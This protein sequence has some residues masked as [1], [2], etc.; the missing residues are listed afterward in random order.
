[1]KEGL[2]NALRSGLILG[3]LAFSQI[4][5][6][7]I[8]G[9]GSIQGTISDPTG[10]V[11][12]GATV[13]ATNTATG[14]KT[15]RTTTA[16]GYYVLSPLPAG[17]YTVTASSTG[18]QSTVQQ[19]IRVDALAT[20]GLN[21]T[22]TVGAATQSVT[23]SS[24][25]PQLDTTNATLG[26]TMRNEV[27]TALPLAMSGGPRDP[28]QF[29][30]LIPG[31]Q[32]GATQAAGTSYASFNGG[33]TYHN[34]VYVE[35]VPLTNAAVQGETRNLSLG[36]SVE[37]IDQFQVETNSA[38]AM[39]QGQGVENYVLKSGGDQFHGAA[40][41]HF[42]NTLLDARGFFPPT[43]PVEKQNEF[44]ANL[45]GPIRKDKLFFF[46]SYDGYRYR[47]GSVPV[48]QSIPTLAE[49]SGD[50]SALPVTIY[51]PTTT[52]CTG[53][54]TGCTRQPFPGNIIPA[55][56]ISK[57][58][59]S[60]QSYLPTPINSGLQNNYLSSLPIGLGVNNTTN[61]VD[62]NISD[63]NRF[64]ALYS[65]GKY[66]TNGLASI[67]TG[68]QTP[69]PY[70]ES[71][72]VQ[73]ISTTAQVHDAYVF[74]AN[75]LNQFSYSF[76]RL[77]V[78]ILSATMN[79]AYPEKAGLTGL[80]PGQASLAFPRVTFNGPNSPIQWSGTN[81]VAFDEALN[82][83]S[84]QDNMQWIHGR[85]SF[86]FGYQMQWLQDNYTSPDT[87]TLATFTFSNN[88]TAGF[89]PAGTLL[90]TTGNSYASYLLGSLD[91][92]GITEN[93]V[94]TIGARYR[95]YA[96]YIQD[97]FKVSPR[98]TLN[99]G[100]RYDI[101]GPF[102]E[103]RNRM[104]FLN[105]DLPNPAV[106]GQPGV[107]QFSGS[108]PFSCNCDTPVR[109]HYKNFGPRIGLAFKA[110]ENTVLRAGY[111]IM[112]ARAGGVGGRAGG[113][114]G[115]G[116]LGYSANPP[117]SSL[118]GGITPAFYWDNGIP[119]YQHPPFFD[120]TLNTGF[121]TTTPAGGG[122]T[123]GDT[124]IGAK[125]P[126]YENWNVSIQRALAKDLTLTAA[127]TASAGHFLGT[128]VGRP[129]W[130]DQIDPRYLALG[131]LLRAQATPANLAAAQAIVPG[132]GLPYANFEGTIG[133]MLRPF[134]QYN[135]VSDIWGDIGNSN[136]NAFQIK[137]DKRLSRGLVFNIGYTLSKELDDTGTGRTAFN[138]GI[139]KSLG[140]T[141]R[142]HAV[143]VT[144]VYHLPFGEGHQWGSSNG[145]IKR[146][147]SG[148]QISGLIQYYSG[149]PLALT[150]SGCNAPYTGSCYPSYNPAYNGPARIN[151]DYGSGTAAA[152]TAY[153]NKD[154]F[155]DPA[156]FAFGDVSRT[157]PFGLRDTSTFELDTSLRRE[158]AITERVK[159]AFQA[160]AFNLP[161]F[162]RFS[163]IGTNID[164]SS[165]GRVT[166]QG[167][168][169]RKFQLNAR[170]LF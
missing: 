78:P 6:A 129:V 49:R 14:V 142:T 98:L 64:F 148:W 81:A 107:L 16:A 139:E 41:E 101:F 125:P 104:S 70:T 38:P 133:Q 105:P 91:S 92:A 140:L 50:F 170:I 109:T 149:A 93:A 4:L 155:E 22:L 51:D 66:A 102:K 134:P 112:Y 40:Y 88:E 63:K 96:A 121:N 12:P 20:V 21:L 126:Y 159:L 137:L 9:S 13:E 130:S 103:V 124:A 35:G 69:L 28:T 1:M 42:R 39:Y 90:T 117:L 136:Y 5:T 165:F 77:Y 161:N 53:A 52:M 146:A 18:F 58:S 95:N 55:D 120:S 169:P 65:F 75:L 135:G 119:A 131:N 83:F 15:S 47:Q 152:T 48:L 80:P 153:I 25:P 37:A 60:L 132:I 141:D 84:L 23:V 19:H 160:D 157:A 154:A 3:A 56:R 32:A 145:L 108:G 86:T 27:Y 167:N 87:G 143:N 44:G 128:G 114:N 36:I 156:A 94:T 115:T 68:N 100:L 11:I 82:T 147:V 8:G 166:T 76:N 24:A 7:Q 59:Q 54:G 89:S 127:Y 61:K 99:L 116:Q 118:D 113:R 67:S 163:G 123:Y 29:V 110:T 106:D 30:N 150:A 62:W 151:G 2:R 43:T 33:Q 45:S 74:S 138:Q 57:V 72:I 158:F 31:V 144:F 17:E 111:A 73:E 79:G 164:S 97:D 162:T 71:R 168:L 10:A 85:H 46:T 26:G 34:E 122:I